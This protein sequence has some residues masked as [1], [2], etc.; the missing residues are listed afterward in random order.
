MVCSRG[1]LLVAP[2]ATLR[3]FKGVIATNGRIRFLGIATLLLGILMAMAGASEHGGLALLISVIGWALVGMSTLTLLLFPAAYRSIAEALLPSD[4]D[5][6]L[7][8]WRFL[9]LVGV[10][11]GGLLVYFGVLAL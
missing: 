9:G 7:T 8:G 11:I 6:E 4:E 1:P 10:I 5:E 3:W 2:K